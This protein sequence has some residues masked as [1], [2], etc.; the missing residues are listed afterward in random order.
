MLL[1]AAIVLVLFS[2]VYLFLQQPK[3]GRRPSGER[4]EKIKN[5]PNYSNGQFQ[6][7]SFTPDLT[8][9]A[10]FFTVLKEFF[11]DKSKRSKPANTLPSKKVDLLN[12]LPDE[13]ILVWFGHSS[14]FMQVDGKTIL[15]DPVLSGSASPIRF[16]TVSFKGS[17]VYTPADFPAIDYLFIT[18]D[19]WDHLDYDTVIK[20]KPKIKKI[21]TGLGT[22]AHLQRWGFADDIVIEK[23]WDEVIPLD[24]G[25]SVNTTPGRHF[26][27]RGMK[28][29][30][31]IWM[32]FVL[33]TP[34]L[35]IFIG[36]D[37][38]YDAHF[39]TIGN[40]YGPFDLAILECGQY[41]RY[42]KHIHMMPEEVVQ[43]AIDLK[44]KTL[45]P[46]HWAKFALS[47]HAWDE[48]IKR[49]TIEAAKRNMPVITAMIGE[50]VN[51]GTQL[52][53]TNDWWENID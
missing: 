37:S 21:I 25:F 34:T 5:S 27:G 45:L 44:T 23:D 9:G 12:L 28:R 36:G 16:T 32:S 19:H 13:N 10:N 22:G 48:P 20:L 49:V 30:R 1:F 3:F 15:V 31:A 14:Y 8:D 47:L 41:N 4:L 17:D 35:K 11:F 24:H 53:T 39:K 29:N 2:A 33:S 46:V 7:L 52:P 18:H 38:G 42:W 6:N 51:L 40:T 43:A 50:A 26:S